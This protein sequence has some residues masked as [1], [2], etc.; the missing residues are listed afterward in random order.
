MSMNVELFGFHI[1]H[2]IYTVPLCRTVHSSMLSSE[3][4]T[5]VGLTSN[6]DAT[7]HNVKCPKMPIG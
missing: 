7:A 2:D 3:H 4:R 5:W 1:M 6:Q